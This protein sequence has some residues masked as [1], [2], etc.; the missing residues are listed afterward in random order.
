MS[1]REGKQDR[2]TNLPH[3]V[4]TTNRTATRLALSRW[5]SRFCVVEHALFCNDW[6]PTQA[7]P[8]RDTVNSTIVYDRS[9]AWAQMRGMDTEEWLESKLRGPNVI[10]TLKYYISLG[11]GN[12]GEI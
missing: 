4:Y 9:E 1:D 5:R 7:G 2:P 6:I 11:T 3:L 8:T 12:S 10:Y